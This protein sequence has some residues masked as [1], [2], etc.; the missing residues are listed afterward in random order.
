MRFEKINENKLKIILSNNELPF[1]DSLDSFMTD[2]SDARHSFL[3]ML[4]K[5]KEAVG[6]DTK[7]F[8]IKIQARAISD[9]NFEFLV[10]KLININNDKLVVRPKRILKSANSGS[11][12][13]YRFD[14]FDDF[15]SFCRFL[16][17]N[18]VN[19]LN[20]LSKSCKLFKY[21]KCYYLCFEKINE[22]YKKISLFYSS[23]TEFSKFF[24]SKDLFAYTLKEHGELLFDNNAILTCQKHFK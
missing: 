12:T 21:S 22:N 1:S 2:T 24:S 20:T 8:K 16:K 10:T 23:I 4:D 13:V 7:D 17:F 6:F 18:K 15:C 19:Y 3:V 9:G 5:A 11:Y 14:T